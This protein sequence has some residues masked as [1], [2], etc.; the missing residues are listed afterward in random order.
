MDANVHLEA[1]G[2]AG[3]AETP[4]VGGIWAA[5]IDATAIRVAAIGRMSFIGTILVLRMSGVSAASPPT[6]QGRAKSR[7]QDRSSFDT[8][9]A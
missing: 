4:V 5:A 8:F 1:G 3:V 2:A 9:R 6:L 7:S